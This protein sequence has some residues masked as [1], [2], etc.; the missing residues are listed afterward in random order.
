MTSGA[1]V[2]LP[3]RP[4]ETSVPPRSSCRV[5]TFRQGGRRRRIFFP[6]RPGIRAHRVDS[7]RLLVNYSFST[8]D[9]RCAPTILELTIDANDDPLPGAGT[10]ARVHGRR[11]TVPVEVPPDLT[12]AD[13][14][15]ATART[16]KGVPSDASAVLID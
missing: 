16:K 9:R 13:V 4:A 7:E 2:I 1:V 10:V 6:P 5:E 8:V 15:R 14:V 11:G 3:D 12:N